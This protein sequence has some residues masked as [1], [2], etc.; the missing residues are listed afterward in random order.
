LKKELLSFQELVNGRI[1]FRYAAP[2]YV[3]KS[4]L[5]CHSDEGYKEGEVRGG[6]SVS[7]D[8]ENSQSKLR[9]NNY[10]IALFSLATTIFMLGLVYFYTSTLIQR[11]S[12]ALRQIEQMAISDSLTGI[13][14]RRHSMSRFAEELEKAKREQAALGCIMLDIDNFKSVNDRYGHQRGDK[15]LREV[16]DRLKHS[17]RIYDI[18]GRYGGEEFL[19]VLPGMDL[20]STRQLAE[21]IR[22]HLKESPV[23]DLGITISLGISCNQKVDS[24]IDEIIKR[25]DEGLYRAKQAG[26]DR[27]G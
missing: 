14:N 17:L 19:I 20:E 15:V 6:I 27:V 25:A 7:F 12:A 16:A 23:D 3:D 24:S 1:H 13:F 2:L 9:F 22:L 26:R 5:Q 21:R 10:I 18:L 4:C 8:I 11:I